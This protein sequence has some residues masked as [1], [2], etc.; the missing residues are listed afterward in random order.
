MVKYQ[1]NSELLYRRNEDPF[2]FSWEK[3]A[4]LW[5]NWMLTIPKRRNPSLDKTGRYCAVNQKHENV[6]FLTGTFGNIDLIKRRCIIPAGRAIFFPILVKED[7][8]TEDSDLRT[9]ADLVNRS[10]DAT[11]EVI[12]IDASIDDMKIEN[13]ETYRVQSEVFDLNYPEGNVYG[14]K[15]GLTHAVCDGFWL[16]IKPLEA[17]KH[18]IYFRGETAVIDRYIHAWL[19]NNNVYKPIHEHINRNSTFKLDVLYEVTISIRRDSGA[20]L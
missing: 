12:Y 19:I 1:M 4:A 7:S 14:I 17:G 13:L 10:R 16:F 8:L 11:N 2:G 6:W 18:Y 5:C 15:P 9:V 20:T 3:W